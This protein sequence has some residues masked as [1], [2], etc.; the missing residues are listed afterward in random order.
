[1]KRV[2][3]MIVVLSLIPAS[4]LV[5]RRIASE[6]E[7]PT[8]TILMDELALQEQAQVLGTTTFELAER[9]RELGLNG[10]VLYEDTFES[11][12]AEGRIRM[13]LGP[14][15][16]NL[17]L[18]RGEPLPDISTNSMLVSERQPGSLEWLLAKNPPTD[19]QQVEL[20]GHTWY[21]FP[22]R[23]INERPAGLDPAVVARWAEAGY[24]IAIRP[25][26]FPQMRAV[27]QDFP[28]EA[29]YII[30]AGLQVA[31]FPNGLEQLVEASQNHI[32]GIIEGTEQ[33]GMREIARRVPTA[34]L[35]SFNQ[36]YINL[37]L[38]P[39]DLIDKYLLAAN[40]RGIRILYIRPYTRETQG[41]M[42][43]NTEALIAGLR[44]RLAQ[45][46]YDV[47]PL[48]TLAVTYETVPLLRALSGVGI[49]AGLGLLALMYPGL[50]GPFIAFCVLA[51]GVLANGLSWGAL[52]L[53]A[54][55]IFP[56]IGFGHLSEKLHSL[57]LATVISLA[58]AALLSAV[59]S[60]REAMMALTPF[61][62]VGATLVVPPALFIFHYALRYRLPREWVVDF[63][64]TPI[65]LGNVVILFI[66][67]AAVGLAFLRRGNFPILPA[68]EAE[69]TVRSWLN[70]LFVRPR[71]KELLGHPTAV[72]ALTNP[73][74]AAWI[75]A[76]LLTGGVV[77]QASILNSFSH[78]HTPL[79]ISLQRTIIA[80][81]IGTVIGLVIV[82]LARLLVGFTRRWL[83]GRVPAAS[84][85]AAPS[86]RPGSASAIGEN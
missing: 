34:R 14:E 36:D 6:G 29:H 59:G 73:K 23:L 25:R 43:D 32:T 3:W 77:A 58:G 70:S 81:I 5:A 10:I 35:L 60:D 86:M 83:S 52:A 48:P 53:T 64:H 28:E 41:D 46:G 37:R 72:V 75:K 24:D 51:L 76:G 63:W 57:G 26:N 22:G 12:A 74:W 40:E 44:Q 4:V 39:E 16:V 71:F 17:A 21:V 49:L 18:S 82:P 56:V 54:A 20:A 78:Y 27:G 85:E 33:D 15:A 55:L 2:L 8:V 7:R 47:G 62:G 9:Y 66:G 11:A 30:H 68:T 84:Q 1:M 67:L 50:W 61:A 65:R 69:L 38:S 80:L 13:L 19:P 45:E 79:V 31:G 42:F